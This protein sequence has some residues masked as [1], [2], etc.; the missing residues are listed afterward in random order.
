MNK[1]EFIQ[2]I[3]PGAL[4]GY[5]R[6]D[7][8]PSLTIAQA[9]LESD[10]GRKHIDNNLFGIKATPSWKGKVAEVWTTEYIN[11]KTQRVK[12]L[13]RAYDSFADS[14]KDHNKLLGEASRYKPV[15]EA[16]NY[17]DACYAVQAC[18]YATD[19]QYANKLIAIIEANNLVQYDYEV[20]VSPWAKEAW[21]KA[22][23]KGVQDGFGPK[24]TVT[25]EQL[26]V[27][28]DKLGL[29]D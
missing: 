12:A 20:Q 14:V 4:D 22:V 5:H 13:F 26:M 15:R 17:K 6:Y 28:F 23:A 7:I 9:I 16:T 11:G 2:A 1:E 21:D 10:W 3:L 27:F 19:P 29:L 8:L 18:G 25:E 24:A